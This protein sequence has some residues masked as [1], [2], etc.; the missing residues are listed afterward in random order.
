MRLN[1]L[2][3]SDFVRSIA[4]L[5]CGLTGSCSFANSIAP[6]GEDEKMLID[7]ALNVYVGPREEDQENILSMSTPVVVYLPDMECV[8]FKANKGTIGGEFTVCF[9]R[10][11]GS[12]A[13]TYTEGM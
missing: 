11:D 9:N 1:F 12:L 7:R 2:T 13:L 8:A 3:K 6:P 5:S 4:L 10:A